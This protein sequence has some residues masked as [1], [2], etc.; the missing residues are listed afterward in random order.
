MSLSRASNPLRKRPRL[1]QFQ[2]LQPL[3]STTPTT[4]TRPTKLPHTSKNE[5]TS[6]IPK[7]NTN[8]HRN[9]LF[10]STPCHHVA[11]SPS[12][13]RTEASRARAAAASASDTPLFYNQPVQGSLEDR[14]QSF[15]KIKKALY[16]EAINVGVVNH[17]RLNLNKFSHMGLA[18]IEEAYTRAPSGTAIRAID[19]GELV[20]V[21]AIPGII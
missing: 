1:R 16:G 2:P 9:R 6:T 8:A 14:K 21:L 20:A 10:H 7:R 12:I 4:T 18:L 19:S 5:D 3:F 13:R 11:R 17:L 15:N